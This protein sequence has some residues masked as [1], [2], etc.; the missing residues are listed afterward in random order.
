[1]RNKV[2]RTMVLRHATRFFFLFA[3]SLVL[4]MCLTELAYGSYTDMAVTD[5]QSM[6]EVEIELSQVAPIEGMIS[7]GD[8]VEREFCIKSL[9]G[10]CYIRVRAEIVAS[11]DA[12][13]PE[14]F[15]SQDPRWKHGKDGWWYFCE[16]VKARSEMEFKFNFSISGNEPFVNDRLIQLRSHDDAV[17]SMDLSEIVVA[18]AIQ[19]DAVEPNWDY[20]D[21]WSANGALDEVDRDVDVI[22]NGKAASSLHREIRSLVPWNIYSSLP[23]TGDSAPLL[24]ALLV[25]ATAVCILYATHK[26]KQTAQEGKKV[27]Q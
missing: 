19:A 7:I 9:K 17:V 5:K 14:S 20:E 24:T 27:K 26:G 15:G 21:P 25:L 23:N 16:P 10:E 22:E 6:N 11:E 1:M 4:S 3:V 8:T 13:S 12:K 18:E 2:K